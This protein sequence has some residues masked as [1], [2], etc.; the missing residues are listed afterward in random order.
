MLERPAGQCEARHGPRGAARPVGGARRGHHA[1][2]GDERRR[3]GE[4]PRLPRPALPRAP[5]AREPRSARFPGLRLSLPGAV[6]RARGRGRDDDGDVTERTRRVVRV[7]RARVGGQPLPQGARRGSLRGARHVRVRHPTPGAGHPARGHPRAPRRARVRA[8][9]LRARPPRAS[10]HLTTRHRAPRPQGSSSAPSPARRGARRGRAPARSRAPIATRQVLPRHVP[11]APGVDRA[12]R[13]GRPARGV[14]GQARGGRRRRRGVYLGDFD[15][16]GAAKA[17]PARVARTRVAT[18]DKYGL[19]D[20]IV[21]GDTAGVDGGR[22]CFGSDDAAIRRR[23]G[24]TS[25]DDAPGDDG[26]ERE[27]HRGFQVSLEALPPGWSCP[28]R[29]LCSSRVARCAC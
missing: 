1:R 20:S 29:R 3:P 9:R 2:A 7:Q 8:L 4:I 24:G 28:R 23:D 26:G 6:R 14:L 17:T 5:R 22:S 19:D 12:R 18:A 10:R 13:A 25:S 27:W 21:D 16:S 15:E 11:A